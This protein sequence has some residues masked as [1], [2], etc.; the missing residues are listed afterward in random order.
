MRAKM[1]NHEYRR[2][3]D[4]EADF[5]LMISNCLQFNDR[6]TPFYKQGVKMRDQVPYT[7]SAVH[8]AFDVITSESCAGRCL[9]KILFTCRVLDLESSSYSSMFSFPVSFHA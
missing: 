4:F 9:I 6:D 1:E 8:V 7:V 3:E 2:M 5:D